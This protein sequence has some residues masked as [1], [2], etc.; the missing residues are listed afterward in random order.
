MTM[1]Y[2]V[3]LLLLGSLAAGAMGCAVADTG[4]FSRLS[5]EVGILKKEVAAMK[6]A[7]TAPAG[8]EEVSGLRRTVADLGSDSDRLKSDQLAAS[9][10]LDETQAELKRIA[11]RQAEQE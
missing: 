4:A 11:D 1:R 7:S 6:S 5:E 8:S 2:A 10:R 9:S 3:R